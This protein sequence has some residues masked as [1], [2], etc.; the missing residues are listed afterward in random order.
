MGTQWKKQL[1]PV[2]IYAKNHEI[3]VKEV[4]SSISK[5]TDD[6]HLALKDCSAGTYQIIIRIHTPAPRTD[7]I[8][9]S[10]ILSR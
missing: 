1:I 9:N 8:L 10:N 7:G 2:E 5:T 3:C 6:V 4:S